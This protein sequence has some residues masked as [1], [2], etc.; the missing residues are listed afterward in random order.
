MLKRLRGYWAGF[1]LLRDPTKLN[2]VFE[3]RRGHPQPR[4]GAGA[5]RG[6]RAV[7]P[8]RGQGAR[9]EAAAR[10]RP[11]QAARAP[12]QHVRARRRRLLRTRTRSTRRPSPTSR[13]KA[14]PRGSR[15]TSTKRTTCGTS[16]RASRPTSQASSACRPSTPRSSRTAAD[17]PRARRLAARRVLAWQDEFKAAAG[18]HRAR[19]G[20][21]HARCVRSS[22]CAGTP[23]GRSPSYAVRA[24]AGALGRSPGARRGQGDSLKIP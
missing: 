20:G 12:R 1:Q 8:E 19:M 13:R 7:R 23:C 21:L 4:R 18:G 3:D 10:A 2:E 6:R 24:G 15:P 17:A 22:A 14:R 16:R 11:R 9:G 5:D